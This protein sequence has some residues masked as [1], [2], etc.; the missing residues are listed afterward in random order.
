[1]KLTIERRETGEKLELTFREDISI[2]GDGSGTDWVDLFT[3]VLRWA[4]FTD[5]QIRELFKEEE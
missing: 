1:M 3:L 5:E 2:Y 4:S